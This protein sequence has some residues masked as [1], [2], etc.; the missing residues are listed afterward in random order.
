MIKVVEQNERM[1]GC[2]VVEMSQGNQSVQFSLTQIGESLILSINQGNL[3][4]QPVNNQQ[5]NIRTRWPQH[6]YLENP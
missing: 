2:V 6:G 3:I 1:G 5:V 4:I